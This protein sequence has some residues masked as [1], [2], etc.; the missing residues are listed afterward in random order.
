MAMDYLASL[1]AIF[2][3]DA[4]ITGTGASAVLSFKPAQT[5]DSNNFQNPQLAK[6]EAILLALLQKAFLA[7][8]ITQARAMEVTRTSVLTV[9]DN[10][11][12]TG[13]QFSVRI[14]S[15]TPLTGVDPD[16]L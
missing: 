10:T 3:E 12:V 6:P 11:Q 7:Q 5:G 4:A 1:T 15:G 13:E 8:G 14:F 9:K 16:T 2:G